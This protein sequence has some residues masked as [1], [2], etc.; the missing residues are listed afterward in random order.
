MAAKGEY[1]RTCKIDVVVMRKKILILTLNDYI[2]YQPTILNLYDL[3]S[4][5]ADVTVVSFEPKFVTKQKEEKRNI[6]YLK[7]GTVGTELFTKIDFI[8]SKFTPLIKKVLPKFSHHYLF[9][10]YYLPSVVANYLQREKPQ[11][12]E[13]IA[14]DLAVLLVAQKHFGAVNFL[15]LEIDN[16]TNPNYKKVDTRKI[17]SVFVQSQ[18]RYDYLFPGVS[19][20]K[21]IVQNSPVYK[22]GPTLNTERKDFIWAGAIDRRLAVLE[23]IEF[24]NQ[25]PNYKLV[26]KGGGDKKTRRIIEERYGH[27]LRNDRLIF[28]QEYLEADSFVDFLA[29]F[30]IGFCFYSWSLIAASF[31]Y[32][33]A[34][35][36]KLFMYLAAG[37]PVI[38]CNIPGFDF[39]KEFGA[40]ELIDDYEP[41]TIKRAIEKIETNYESYRQ[42]CYKA[43]SYFS[44]DNHVQPYINH[45]L[46]S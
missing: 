11:A 39:V 33:S 32:Q 45:L 7:M 43:A 30:K 23:C 35:S 13:V 37:T 3:L 42:G 27:L 20:K 38:A 31:N 34:P 1:G 9:Y 18:M 12:D 21:F 22:P 19:L 40:G 36:G 15:S 8:I 24:F 41:A 16:N 10:N 14:V 25:Y 46:N 2:L 5:H 29:S 28:N 6:K 4:V 44:F 17:K 26:M